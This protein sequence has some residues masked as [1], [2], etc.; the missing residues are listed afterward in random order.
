MIKGLLTRNRSSW[1]Y[2]CGEV[3]AF[4]VALL[5]LHAKRSAGQWTCQLISEQT[6]F[7]LAQRT[8]KLKH[9]TVFL[10]KL[11]LLSMRQIK[12]ALSFTKLNS[13]HWQKQISHQHQK[14]NFWELL[15][16]NKPWHCHCPTIN[17][18]VRKIKIPIRLRISSCVTFCVLIDGFECL[19]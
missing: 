11:F 10:L 3:L 9:N 18:R 16:Y 7:L 1:S 5:L 15:Q 12:R 13:N 6:L 8:Y 14:M 17:D 4:F 2:R 19:K